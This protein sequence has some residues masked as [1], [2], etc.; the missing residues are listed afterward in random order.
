[1]QES[2]TERCPYTTLLAKWWVRLQL[3]PN[4]HAAI[5]HVCITYKCEGRL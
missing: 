4:L 3:L 2:R 1:M 5:M